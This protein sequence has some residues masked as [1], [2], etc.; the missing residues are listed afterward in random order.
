MGSAQV[1]DWLVLEC[2]GTVPSPAPPLTQEDGINATFLTPVILYAVKCFIGSNLPNA[3]PDGA[4]PTA[5]ASEGDPETRPSFPAP[6]SEGSSGKPLLNL[7]G[8]KLLEPVA[9]RTQDA[10]T[11]GTDH[12]IDSCIPPQDMR[13][14]WRVRSCDYLQSSSPWSLVTCTRTSPHKPSL[15]SEVVALSLVFKGLESA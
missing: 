12:E 14:H 6:S 8:W 15:C 1:T 4:C 7:Q 5:R 11:Q 13:S 2:L 9:W 10:T 3:P